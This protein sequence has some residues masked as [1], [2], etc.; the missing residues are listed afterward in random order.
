MR[1]RARA[2]ARAREQAGVQ[3]APRDRSRASDALRHRPLTS[4]PHALPSYPSRPLQ[5]S[6]VTQ[7]LNEEVR[8]LE[9]VE[10][11]SA[12]ILQTAKGLATRAADLRI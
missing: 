7:L 1:A 4:P 12:V 2:R 5:L 9:D 11:R 8:N 3:A 6:Q 10:R